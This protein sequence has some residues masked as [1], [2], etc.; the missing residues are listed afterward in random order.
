MEKYT[1]VQKPR[2]KAPDNEVRV[3]KKSNIPGA[4]K[5]IISQFREKKA[6]E[7]IVKSMGVAISKITT[8]AEI[9]KYRVAGLHQFNNIE[10]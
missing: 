8:S 6:T 1:R 9:V 4:A 10:T 2:D 7:V 3:T 5:Y